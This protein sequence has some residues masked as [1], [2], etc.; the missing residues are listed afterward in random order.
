MV[1][2]KGRGKTRAEA[3]AMAKARATVKTMKK[4]SAMAKERSVVKENA[5]G[6]NSSLILWPVFFQLCQVI[7]RTTRNI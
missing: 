7:P 4:T 3:R 6:F 2:G 5:K 1:W